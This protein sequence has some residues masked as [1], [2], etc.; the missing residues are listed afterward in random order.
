MHPAQENKEGGGC[1][2][3][4]ARGRCSGGKAGC[5]AWNLVRAGRAARAAGGKLF[6]VGPRA[7]LVNT[8]P[9]AEGSRPGGRRHRESGGSGSP[10][11]PRQVKGRQ[12]RGQVSIGRRPGSLAGP[13]AGG[14]GMTGCKYRSAPRD[15]GDDDAVG[16]SLYLFIFSLW[17]LHDDAMDDG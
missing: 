13:G 11:R 16:F 14:R 12:R 10:A 6:R 1:R 9:G 7:A 15:S 3:R 17:R 5:A 2:A 4:S 8:E